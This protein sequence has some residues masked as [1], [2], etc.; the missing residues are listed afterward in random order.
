MFNLLPG[1]LHIQ[2][3]LSSSDD[4]AHDTWPPTFLAG[5]NAHPCGSR[6][7]ALVK[8][9]A[10]Q[11]GG[12]PQITVAPAGLR[13]TSLSGHRRAG[14]AGLVRVAIRDQRFSIPE[15]RLSFKES[16]DVSPPPPPPHAHPSRRE[17]QGARGG[18]GSPPPREACGPCTDP[19]CSF[20]PARIQFPRVFQASA[21][22][23]G[24]CPLR[25]ATCRLKF[26]LRGARGGGGVGE[27]SDLHRRHRRGFDLI[28]SHTP[29]GCVPH[30]WSQ[31]ISFESS[32]FPLSLFKSFNK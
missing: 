9:W 27:T 12:R 15:G 23:A 19:F 14:G 10:W 20:P 28:P 11:S 4:W 26:L 3:G 22:E 17:G 1:G 21:R 25:A 32:F 2:Q 31:D 5:M 24:K 8:T 29:K 18:Y 16:Q 13:G 30:I 7:L 6:R